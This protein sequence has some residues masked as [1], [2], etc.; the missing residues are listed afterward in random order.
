MK[1]KVLTAVMICVLAASLFGCNKAKKADPQDVADTII[2][3]CD[4][5][6]LETVPVAEEAVREYIKDKEEDE[7]EE[8]EKERKEEEENEDDIDDPVNADSTEE[9]GQNAS[10]EAMTKRYTGRWEMQGLIQSDGNLDSSSSAHC[11]YVFNADHTY[12]ARGVDLSGNKIK[13]DGSWKLNSNKQ[14][15]AGKFTMGIDESGYLLKD[16]GERDGKGRKIK[17]AF[18]KVS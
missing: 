7:E 5:V 4:E 9:T 16:T 18:A 2:A 1:Y 13:E 11:T 8:R 3:L 12:T 15:V 17:Y 6:S 10:P 14:I